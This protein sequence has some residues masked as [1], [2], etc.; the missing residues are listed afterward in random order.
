MN[1]ISKCHFHIQKLGAYWFALTPIMRVPVLRAKSV[2]GLSD[3]I[4]GYLS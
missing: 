4:K 2:R 1:A 3:Q